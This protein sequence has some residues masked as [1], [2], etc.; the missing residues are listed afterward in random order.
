MKH[1]SLLFLLT[2]LVVSCEKTTT[3]QAPIHFNSLDSKVTG[4]DFENTLTP[5]GAMN[6]IEYLYYYNGGGVGIIDIDKDGLDDIFFTGNQTPDKLYR[7]LGNMKFEDI[8]A[9][10]GI[11]TE[12]SW[13]TGVTVADVN[14]D[15]FQDLFV[16]K[17]SNY[18]SLEEAHHMLY[19]NNGDMT[20]SE[21]SEE[22][23][24]DIS[25]F[26]T[27][28]SFFDYDNDGDLDVYLLNHSI[29][30]PRNYGRSNQ[31]SK[32]DDLAGDLLLENKLNE[33]TLQ[34]VDVTNAAGIYSS[35]LGYGLGLSTT[36]LN[37]D[38]LIDIYVGNDFHENDY[39]YINQGDKTF[40]EVSNS[41]LS[42]SSRFSMGL[43]AADI[44]NDGLTDLFTLDM[45]P[46]DADIFMKSGG[47]DSDKVSQIKELYGYHPQF[48]RNHLQLNSGDGSFKE[49]AMISGLHATDWSWSVL[50]QDYDNDGNSDIFIS[51]G[52]YKR[53]NDLD[54]INYESDV[55]LS[56]FTDKEQDELELEFI[57]VMPSL[58]IS[59]VVFKNNGDYQFDRY[60][61]EAGLS[62]SYSNGAAYSDLDNDGDLDIVINN[63]NEA[64]SILEN[65]SSSKNYLSLNLSDNER[66]NPMGT[67]VYAYSNGIKWYRELTA[68]RGFESSSSHRIHLGIGSAQQLDSI[69][70]KWLD[71]TQQI[72]TNIT[73]NQSLTISKE[74]LQQQ[75]NSVVMESDFTVKPFAF[76]HSENDFL[77]YEKEP[78]IPERLSIEGPALE[79]ADFNGDG[80]DDLY[81]GGGKYQAAALFLQ[82]RDGSYSE[83][84]LELFESDAIHEDEDAEA[85]DFDKDGDLDLYVVSGGNE[86]VE[87]VLHTTD[88]MYINNGKAD[89][90][91]YPAAL[92]SY[93][94]GA[95]AAGDYDGDGYEDL[96][97]G[98][99]SVPGGYGLFPNSYILRNTQQANFEMVAQAR[100]GMIT[101]SQWADLNNDGL[102]DLVYVGDWIPISVLINLGGGKFDNQTEE[103]GLSDTQGMWN[104][105]KVADVDQNGTMDIIAGNAGLN[106]KWK[107]SKEQPIQLYLDDYDENTFLDPIIF[108]NFFG[109]SVPFAS[110]DKLISQIPALKKYFVRYSDFVKA[111]DIHTLTGKDSIM[112]TKSIKELR[113]MVFLNENNASYKAV[114]L[115]MEAQLSSIEDVYFDNGELYYVGN[116]SGYVTELGP[117]KSN[118]GGVLSNFKNGNFTQNRSLG[119]PAHLEGRK[120]DKISDKTFIILTNNDSAYTITKK[121]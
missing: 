36:D 21:Q 25:R 119:L 33:G 67:K 32:T 90:I 121:N 53:P 63:I 26:G 45:M 71:G 1:Y 15:G 82:Q 28:A 47:E 68:T 2:V 85:F 113:S 84:K 37:M 99:R 114:P 54:F 58:K 91:K 24:L 46:N 39:I 72:L 109:S 64:A 98:S 14:N 111:K 108:Y 86:Y 30:T 12:E 29:H 80:L 102:L 49:A 87:G 55:D 10:A 70:V 81:L 69:V 42:H 117:S 31:R 97:L 35:S 6:I 44:N 38:G 52:I 75:N 34:F 41:A 8:S 88:R 93:N 13:S 92:P 48:A 56:K 60:T 83:K 105:V 112:E 19:I 11:G 100:L 101:D 120:I 5:T 103:F 89:F 17:V 65:N 40:K 59:N 23:G 73:A 106:L 115:P 107:A 18:K 94:G 7:N 104:C 76:T 16:S 4:V 78:L 57:N 95:I 22:V 110:K 51:N 50:I 77:D 61:S 20:F 62:E 43:D 9:S 3:E 96:F 116:Y 27:Q 118:V 74:N 66:F 79:R